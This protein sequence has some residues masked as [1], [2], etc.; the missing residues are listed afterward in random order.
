MAS[1]YNFCLR[2]IILFCSICP[3][4]VIAKFNQAAFDSYALE[5]GYKAANL[6][7]LTK[8]LLPL[9][10]KMPGRYQVPAFFPLGNNEIQ[11]FLSKTMMSDKSMTIMDF[12]GQQLEQ[13]KKIQSSANNNALTQ[14]SIS[15]L[16]SIE[17]SIEQVLTSQPFTLEAAERQKAF[18]EFLA[19]V[20]EQKNLLMVRSTGK[21]DTK[22]LANAGGNKSIAAVKPDIATVSKAMGV[23][24][25]SYFGKKSISQRL[26]ANDKTIFDKPFMPV[27]PQIMIGK[28]P[29]SGVMFSE[30]AEGHTPG[31]THIQATYG[32]GE[33]VVNG[34][35]PVDTFYIG[36]TMLVHPLIRIK[37]YRLVPAADFSHLERVANSGQMAKSPCLS[38]EIVRDLK[39]GANIIQQYYGYP[40]DIEF[41]VENNII[42]LVQARPIVSKDSAPSYLKDEF[43]ASVAEKLPVFTIITAGGTVRVIDQASALII[44][45]NIRKALDTFL[46]PKT[47]KD[48]V[49]AVASGE[50]APATSHEGTTFRGADKAVVYSDMLEPLRALIAGN[51]FPLLIDVQRGL[52]VP[53]TTSDQFMSP[54]AAIIKNAWFVHLIP[55]KTSLFSQFIQ[56]KNGKEIKPEE[57]M[58]DKKTSQLLDII[59]N[60]SFG[61]AVN[62]LKSMLARITQAIVV[63]QKKEKEKSVNPQIIAQL[64]NV[65][66]HAISSAHEVMGALQ[67]WDK[68]AKTI[69]DRLSRL[70]PIVFFEAIITQISMPKE[71]VND[72]SF[73]SVL[74]TELQEQKITKEL[75]MGP[76]EARAYA[77]QYGKAASFA[78]SPQLATQWNTYIKSIGA[79]PQ[80]QQ[81]Q[82]SRMIYDLAKDK[83]LPVWINI[84]FVQAQQNAG[85]DHSKTTELLLQEYNQAQL[86]IA[87]LRKVEASLSTMP[88][89]NWTNPELFEKQWKEFHKNVLNPITDPQFNKHYEQA[90]LLGK[91]IA[92]SFLNNIV[93]QFDLS[94]KML[95]ASKEYKNSDKQ[96]INFRTMIEGYYE[97]LEHLTKIS[98]IQNDLD[99][100]LDKR[101]FKTLDDYLAKIKSS[102]YIN[103]GGSSQMQPSRG[104]NVA[105]A[106]L[107]SKALWARSIGDSPTHE[108]MFSLIHQN[109]LV[110]LRILNKI[111]GIDQIIQEPALVKNFK[112]QAQD[113]T[114]SFNRIRYQTFLIGIDI[115]ENKLI[116]YFN[117]PLR[118]HSNTFQLT[119]N[120]KDKTLICAIQFL[121]QARERFSEMANSINFFSSLNGVKLEEKPVVDQ[122][123]GE[124]NF[125]VRLQN[126]DQIKALF[127]LMYDLIGVTFGVPLVF[128]WATDAEKTL[129]DIVTLLQQKAPLSTD[130]IIDFVRANADILRAEKVI[131]ASDKLLSSGN[132]TI[133]L[134][135]ISSFLHYSNHKLPI[136]FYKA[137]FEKAKEGIQAGIQKKNYQIIEHSITLFNHLNDFERVPHEVIMNIAQ[138]A[139]KLG[140]TNN[141]E[142]YK[143][144]MQ[145]LERIFIS[146]YMSKGIGSQVESF[147]PQ[148]TQ[149]ILNMLATNINSDN[150]YIRGKVLADYRTFLLRDEFWENPSFLSEAFESTKKGMRDTD[151]MNVKIAL[152]LLN[153]FAEKKYKIDEIRSLVPEDPYQYD[154][155]W[156]DIP[157]LSHLW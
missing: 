51:K 155:D 148:M 15:I 151:K 32:H 70:Y 43:V 78:L 27:L 45:D 3:I 80:A 100:L 54:D 73:G 42:Y 96:G 140:Q 142:N 95:K 6:N 136:Q 137:A 86:F 117:I 91:L 13:F 104:F 55:K 119:Y 52:I 67:Q 28:N 53:F 56:M 2:I 156:H 22:E 72:Y 39:I 128:L 40:V 121:G 157:A 60:G 46:D 37:N 49:Q 63:E 129:D 134:G 114:V 12:I 66:A 4:S 71:F 88:L 107:G 29:I 9:N 113:F 110:V 83:V 38:A 111:L 58:P 61:D 153:L 154:I 65:F 106:T 132:A 138:Y 79:L 130:M 82:F 108:D 146:L 149:L 147:I 120:A 102:I 48:E 103:V 64:K 11:V 139:S 112:K 18:A 150:A 57:V 31:V 23:V 135:I 34:L 76:G 44:D 50:L 77:V 87:Q 75:A 92:V 68:S 16:E 62:A 89:N 17:K 97:L 24:I 98:N 118:N 1:L 105:A 30:E 122:L 21:E 126:E 144:G 93:N 133:G 59:K 41:V 5:Y 7:E 99:A 84:S 74:K 26:L 145:I 47:N 109:L 90:P 8:M 123:R 124:L 85:N 125:A 116:Y 141:V 20:A 131:E 36:F 101:T 25:A 81:Q 143:A 127:Y 10:A 69:K 33:G 19:K 152:L 35:V 14:E 94:I 115:Q